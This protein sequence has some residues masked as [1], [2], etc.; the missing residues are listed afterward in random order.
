MGRLLSGINAPFI[1]KVG[2][3][4]GSHRKGVPYIK[5]APGK[6]SAKRQ[7]GEKA[8]QDKFRLAHRW[9]QPLLDFV[10]EGF[11]N[12]SPSVEG[13]LAAKSHLLLN[14]FEGTPPD[15][16]INPARVKL[17]HGSLPLPGDITMEK[18]EGNQLVFSWNPALMTADSSPS[19]QVM[20]LAY[21]IEHAGV[22]YDLYGQLRKTG[23]DVL[24]LP[25]SGQE[26]RTYHVYLAFV[27]AD[28]SRQSDSVYLGIVKV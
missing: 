5:A 25:A 4:V 22:E 23:T 7:P 13:F 18:K 24:S 12:Y 10:R 11:R 9:L 1:G 3:A 2:T 6:R 8:N 15:I 27:A 28:R 16:F 19:D 20:L 21:D 14:A 26:E 17:S